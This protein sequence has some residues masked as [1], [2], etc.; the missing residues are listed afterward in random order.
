MKRV[1]LLFIGVF[2]LLSFASCEE[3]DS[4]LRFSVENIDDSENVKFEYYSVDPAGSTGKCKNSD[5]FEEL[6]LR[7]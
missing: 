3:E 7:V 1:I 5:L 2:S 4:P 6:S